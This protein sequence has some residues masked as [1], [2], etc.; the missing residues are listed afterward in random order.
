MA[1]LVMTANSDKVVTVLTLGTLDDISRDSKGDIGFVY[2]TI[3]WL[4]AGVK[5]IDVTSEHVEVA[6]KYWKDYCR[7]SWTGFLGCSLPELLV[8]KV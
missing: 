2:A 6:E 4:L 8:S 1:G 5:P 3:A 7:D